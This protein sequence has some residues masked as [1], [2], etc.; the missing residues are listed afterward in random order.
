[1]RVL[2]TV[3]PATAHIYPIVPLA[4]ALQ[5]AGHDVRVAIHPD[6]V[7]LVTDAGLT[8]IPLGDREILSSVVEF[9]SNLDLLDGLDD[10]FALDT[11]Q[12]TPQR[13]EV[14]WHGMTQVLAMFTPL[15]QD[16]VSLTERWQPDLV[17]WD[18]FCPAAAVAARISGAAQARILWG[19]DNIAWLRAKSKQQ[20]AD[21]GATPGQDPITGLMRPMLS[22]YGLDYDDELLL[23]QWTID[24]MPPG[25]RLPL[26]L[27]YQSMRRVP[28]NGAA[29]VPDWLLDP[30]EHP[31]VCLT[32]G[33]GGRGRQLFRD[34][35]V[36][37]PEVVDALATLDIELVAT[38][39]AKQRERVTTVPDNVRLVDYVPLSQLLPTCSAIIHHGG[40]GTFAA[41]VAHQVPQ[42]ITPMPF[43]GEHVTAQYVADRG[44]G[45]LIPNTELTAEKLRD[46]LSRLLTEPAFTEGTAALYRE[47]REA[48]GPAE[49]V[50][51][52]EDLTAKHRS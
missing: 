23:G 3:F 21:R 50:P 11:G 27:P 24:P 35:G 39:D 2:F 49:L 1:M 33:V 26:D 47:M 32:L 46:Q 9:N 29:V 44:A 10:S 25:M 34:S 15:L 36:S 22:R 45:L 6:A 8:A 42:L 51:V 28:Y 31:R 41:A 4:W 13:W 48:P 20:L 18:P 14:Q 38:I 40:G 19:Q 5:N 37:F 16:L 12:G 52:L 7:D 17:L 43:W 30:V